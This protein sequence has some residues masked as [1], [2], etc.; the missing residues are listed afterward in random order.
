MIYSSTLA[1][2]IVLYDLDERD[3][4]VRADARLL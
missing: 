3:I 1:V 2:P 4:N